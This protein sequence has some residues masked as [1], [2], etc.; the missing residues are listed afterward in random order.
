MFMILNI[1]K[2]IPCNYLYTDKN[3][4]LILYYKFKNKKNLNNYV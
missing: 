2:Y 4:S 1:Q 3:C